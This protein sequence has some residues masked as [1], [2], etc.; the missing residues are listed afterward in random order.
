M[1][2]DLLDRH[3][4]SS[5]PAHSVRFWG[6][7]GT[8]DGN[9]IFNLPKGSIEKLLEQSAGLEYFCVLA[10][11]GLAI[12]DQSCRIRHVVAGNWVRPQRHL[13][14]LSASRPRRGHV[15]WHH[16]ATTAPRLRRME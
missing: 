7:S 10:V 12:A 1:D 9:W 5:R 8:A 13:A 6:D 16:A 15:V 2:G 14:A 3:D 4:N 11:T